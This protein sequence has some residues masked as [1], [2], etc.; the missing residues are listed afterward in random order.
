MASLQKH[1]VTGKHL[2]EYMVI[3]NIHGSI[4]HMVSSMNYWITELVDTTQ[5][6]FSIIGNY[7]LGPD[8]YLHVNACSD[9][10]LALRHY[11][12]ETHVEACSIVS[13][14]ATHDATYEE[15][16]ELQQSG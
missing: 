4:Q 9:A 5:C 3:V 2:N 6:L 11:K 10:I 13:T 7:T 8:L 12:Q 16:E 14:T 1:E 15:C